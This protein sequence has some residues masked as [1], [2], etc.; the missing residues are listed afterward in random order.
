VQKGASPSA[1]GEH[2]DKGQTYLRYIDEFMRL[3]SAPTML[4][5]QLFPNAKEISET[6][7][8]W[9]AY[10]KVSGAP[11]YYWRSRLLP[12]SPARRCCPRSPARAFTLRTRNHGSF[13][14][15]TAQT[16]RTRTLSL[17]WVTGRRREQ[18]PSSPS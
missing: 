10:R 14:Q 1:M 5:L 12:A 11:C 3:A 9:E 2:T 18:R 17:L 15:G 16:L 4:E 7:A 13:W 6:M 8:V